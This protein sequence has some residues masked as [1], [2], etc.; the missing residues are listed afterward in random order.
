MNNFKVAKR[1]PPSLLIASTFTDP[2][3]GDVE[4]IVGQ[5][6]RTLAVRGHDVTVVTSRCGDG[7]AMQEQVDGHTRSRCRRP[8]APMLDPTSRPAANA[9]LTTSRER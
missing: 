4:A 9:V 8:R 5:Q 7:G 6:A 3:V 2:Q 1:T